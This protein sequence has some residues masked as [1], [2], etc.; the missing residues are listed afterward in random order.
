MK[1]KTAQFGLAVGLI[2]TVMSVDIAGAQPKVSAANR[3]TMRIMKTIKIPP[4][5]TPV[6]QPMTWQ[7]YVPPTD[8]TPDYSPKVGPV[9]PFSIPAST[10]VIAPSVL[11]VAATNTASALVTNVPVADKTIKIPASATTSEK[12]SVIPKPVDKTQAIEKK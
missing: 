1:N 12:T 2:A 5:Y 9:Q 6:Y 11:P 8:V 10:M 7:Q 3:E 4:P